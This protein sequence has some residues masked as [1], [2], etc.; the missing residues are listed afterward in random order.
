MVLLLGLK[1]VNNDSYLS[2]IIRA[3][4]YFL[5]TE[6]RDKIEQI[7]RDLEIDFELRGWAY[8]CIIESRP[9][10]YSP[11]TGK[12]RLKGQRV[13]NKSTSTE[14]FIEMALVY[15][16]P[17]FNSSFTPSHQKET[18]KRNL[19]KPT[20]QK[21][22]G[23]NLSVL[24]D[25]KQKKEL[26]QKV[27]FVTYNQSDRVR[28]RSQPGKWFHVGEILS[29]Y[30]IEAILKPQS[31]LLSFDG[32]EATIQIN[33]VE[34]LSLSQCQI[35]S[36]EARFFLVTGTKVSVKLVASNNYSRPE[37][38][39]STES[40]DEILGNKL[41]SDQKIALSL[42]KKFTHS[43]DKFF[44][45][46]GYA[47]TGKSFLITQYIQWLNSLE[48]N[49]VAACPTN[50]AAKSLRNLAETEGLD[51]EIK[52][53][54]QLLG[55][56]PQLDE[57]TGKELFVSHGNLDW[58][59]Y[60]VIIIDEFSMV[61]RNDF[62][63]IVYEIQSSLLSK[64]V[65]VGDSAQ[66]PPVGEK[67]PIVS[68]S[69]L[70]TQSATLTKVVR[71][72]GELAKIAEAIRSDPKY[73]R[74]IFPFTTTSDHTI[75]CLPES[76]WFERAISRFKSVEFQQN[77]DH[78]RFLAWR[79]KTVEFLNNF[80]RSQLWG[81]DAPLYVPGDRLIAKKP[82]FRPKPGA[83]GKN[84]WGIIVNNSEEAQ[85]IQLGQLCQL[86]FQGQIYDYWKVEVQPSEGKSISL[87]I[88]HDQ[89]K[90]VH[91]QQVQY[92]VKKKQWQNYYDLSQMFDD[93][94]YA[95]ALT[96]HKAQ[97][98]TIDY[99]FLDIADMRECSDRQKLLYTALTR[100][101]TQVLI[102]AD[103]A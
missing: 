68:T 6:N 102:P 35:Q 17:G 60:G 18:Q 58:S 22:D 42:L 103:S 52:T 94:T 83:K 2:T 45:L 50:K 36:L 86:L 16:P 40:I 21:T 1:I 25:T 77:P 79:N 70:I 90:E 57:D 73:S 64:V 31:E 101:R 84:K 72:D 85:V 5:V 87:S 65:F 59:G 20:R 93:V 26:W 91:H 97:G 96:T 51:I 33:D 10:Y 82:L 55:Q 23:S 4:D 80:V 81:E 19:Q 75:L 11:S 69:H 61:N 37:I 9:F 32:K 56:Q 15:S 30:V 95:Y 98:S 53:V 48:M 39:D 28:E 12:W 54:A 99:V 47:G 14:N 100:A 49:F 71:Y 29:N 66:L 92:F 41:T 34:L 63:D 44:R 24:A 38:V 3:I 76:E 7:F 74:T 8:F 43:Q 62:Q 13:W 88:L 78:I 67:E 89:S 27:L 46:T